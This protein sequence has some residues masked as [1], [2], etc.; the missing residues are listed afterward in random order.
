MKLMIVD[1]DAVSRGLLRQIVSQ[2]QGLDIVEAEDGM[3]AWCQLDAGAGAD[4]CLVDV[5]MPRMDGLQ[6]LRRLRQDDRFKRL[7]V[8]ICSVVRDGESIKTAVSL[9]VEGYIL[10]PFTTETVRQIFQR[11]SQHVIQAKNQSAY[12]LMEP[13]RPAA[14]FLDESLDFLEFADAEMVKS[15]QWLKDDNRLAVW[16]SVGNLLRRA[17]KLK[18]NGFTCTMESLESAV[19]NGNTAAALTALDAAE[20]AIQSMLSLAIT[21]RSYGRVGDAGVNAFT[22]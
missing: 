22:A 2:E 20:L 11:A 18:L 8:I 17:R 16:E 14:R 19:M 13:G 12:D 21:M 7:K 1:D 9:D 3:D 15:R 6:L 5:M 4:L 10:K